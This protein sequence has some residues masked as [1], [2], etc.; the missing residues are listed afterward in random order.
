MARK[1]SLVLPVHEVPELSDH[2]T[3]PDSAP[4]HEKT[5]VAWIWANRLC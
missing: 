2:G 3:V 5:R 1:I 4:V